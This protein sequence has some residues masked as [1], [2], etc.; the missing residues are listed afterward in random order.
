MS[1]FG[2]SQNRNGKSPSKDHDF[3]QSMDFM[4][5]ERFRNTIG[6]D[7]NAPSTYRESISNN[8]S[9]RFRNSLD[10]DMARDFIEHI[11]YTKRT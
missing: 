5:N 1:N 2:Y 3:R 9:N 11:S 7:F 10:L 6:F 4:N 8:N